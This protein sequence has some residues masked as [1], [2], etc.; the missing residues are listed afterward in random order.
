MMK[1]IVVIDLADRDVFIE[2]IPDDILESYED[3]TDYIQDNYVL[4]G[5][6]TWGFADSITYIGED[7]DTMDVEPKDWQ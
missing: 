4:E 5:K 2:D 1:R 7:G 3:V 6:W